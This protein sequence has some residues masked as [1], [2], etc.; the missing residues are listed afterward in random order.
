MLSPFYPNTANKK[1]TEKSKKEEEEK[2]KERE[3][4][5]RQQGL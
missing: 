2:I 1:V 4:A 5:A 3:K